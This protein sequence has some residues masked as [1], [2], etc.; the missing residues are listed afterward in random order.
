MTSCA[1]P[2]LQKGCSTTTLVEICKEGLQRLCGMLEV[3]LRGHAVKGETSLH[4]LFSPPL[5]LA[6]QIWGTLR[7][8]GYED[9]FLATADGL[10]GAFPVT[11]S[12][13]KDCQH[14]ISSVQ[15][16]Q[17]DVSTARAGLTK[18][19]VELP[20]HNI[21]AVGMQRGDALGAGCILDEARFVAERRAA[22]LAGMERI[23]SASDSVDVRDLSLTF[24]YHVGS[25]AFSVKTYFDI[26]DGLIRR[27]FPSSTR[28]APQSGTKWLSRYG[29][30]TL[31]GVAPCVELH[32]ACVPFWHGAGAAAAQL[33]PLYH[34]DIPLV[35]VGST[36]LDANGPLRSSPLLLTEE[37]RRYLNTADGSDVDTSTWLNRGLYGRFAGESLQQTLFSGQG[38]PTTRELEVRGVR[39]NDQRNTLE[40]IA[41]DR[42]SGRLHRL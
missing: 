33:A 14:M 19:A 20:L 4:V 15:V 41:V 31:V 26:T 30:A 36:P 16:D 38:S 11:A 18:N 25:D 39:W 32:D 27:Y 12:E 40:Q 28:T 10:P 5:S 42:K 8:E 9:V 17:D 29:T 24:S 37:L 2:L 35:P 1:L 7:G 6:L 3:D 13:L 22:S 34:S 21:V 23:L